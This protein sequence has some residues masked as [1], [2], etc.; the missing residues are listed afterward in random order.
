MTL[1]IDK[2]K[3]SSKLEATF[4]QDLAEYGLTTQILR[5]TFL[6]FALWNDSYE[7]GKEVGPLPGKYLWHAHMVPLTQPI[8]LG[9]WNKNYEKNQGRCTSDRYIFYAKCEP[10]LS[11]LLIDHVI[12]PG[13]HNVWLPKYKKAVDAMEKVAED[14][15]FFQ[16]IP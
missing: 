2:I 10:I 8:S 16:K 14:F 13:G 7:Y 3:I 15:Y 11:Y 9:K 5:Q 4:A 1:T 12:D 6:E